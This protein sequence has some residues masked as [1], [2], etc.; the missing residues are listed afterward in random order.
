MTA[1][2]QHW[3][4]FTVN[5]TTKL[6]PEAEPMLRAFGLPADAQILRTEPLSA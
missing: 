6:K 1:V 2:E 4:D 5:L 3:G